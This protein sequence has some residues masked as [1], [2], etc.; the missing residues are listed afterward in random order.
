MQYRRSRLWLSGIGATAFL[1]AGCGSGSATAKPPSGGNASASSTTSSAPKG[2]SINVGVIGPFTGTSAWAGNEFLDGAKTAADLINQAGGINGHPVKLVDVNTGGDPVDAVPAVRKMLAT[3]NVSLALGLSIVDYQNALPILNQAKMVSFTHIGT[4]ALDH[5]LMPYSFRSQPSDAVVGTAMAWYAHDKHYQ[6]IAV[7]LG[8]GQGA[9]TLQQPI[10]AAAKK[11]GLTVTVN[12]T[13]PVSAGS[14]QAEIEKILKSKPDAILYQQDTQ[15]AGTFSTELQQL[16]GGNIP[17]VG[18]DVTATAAWVKAV[19]VKEAAKEV[20]SIVPSSGTNGPGSKLFLSTFNKL[21]HTAPRTLS[22]NMYDSLNVAAL[23]MVAANSTKPTVYVK[24]IPKVTTP[25]S[26]HTEVYS[27]AQGVKLLKEGK[28]IKYYGVSGPMTYNQYHDVS[29]PFQAV[30]TDT[31]GKYTV[32]LNIPATKL[33][34]L[35]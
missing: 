30:K 10:L 14:Y 26:G 31:K 34:P 32:L 3:D 29:G 19:G 33:T 4:P 2:S 28:S 12:I 1:L 20:V 16:G 35:L 8:A 5:K 27:Y 25:G 9:Q 11:L 7:V 21:F 17:I 18:S 6:K 15:D 24:E 23:A 13:L 22:P